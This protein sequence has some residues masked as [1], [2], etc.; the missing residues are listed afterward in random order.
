[1]PALFLILAFQTANLLTRAQTSVYHDKI[2]HVHKNGNNTESCLIGQE[3]RQ[4]KPDQYCKTLEFV[5]SKLHNSGSRNVSII[6]ESQIQLC[7]AVNFSDHEGLTI[8][9]RSKDTATKLSCKCNKTN[10]I[11]ISFTRINYL[12][13]YSFTVTHCCGRMNNY[14][15]S[16]LI[17]K[18]V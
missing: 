9:G 4:G 7:S 12:K 10:S 17:F 1:M 13:V 2:I 3:M 16:L 18:T 5:A 6:L 14:T 8:Q 15:T 11:G